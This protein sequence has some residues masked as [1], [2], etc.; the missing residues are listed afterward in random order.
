MKLTEITTITSH[1]GISYV[2]DIEVE[3]EHQYFANNILVHNCTTSANVSISYGNATLL[4]EIN[5]IRMNIRHNISEYK[6]DSSPI[7]TETKII[8]DGGIGWFDDIQKSLALGADY[9]MIGKLF[10]ECNEACEP[11]YYAVSEDE[12]TLGNKFTP[13]EM[14]KKEIDCPGCRELFKRYRNYAGMSTKQSQTITGGD[15][16]K[17]SEGISKPVEVKHSVSKFLDNAESYLRSCM[18]YT[19]SKTLDDLKNAEVVILGGT[20]DL[21]YRK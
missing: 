8:A 21:T 6:H 10:A 3:N 20:G 7:F 11:F 9:V 2:Y 18:T 4:D 15:G 17:T 16:S 1:R 12:Y 13:S 5:N 14:F 19:N